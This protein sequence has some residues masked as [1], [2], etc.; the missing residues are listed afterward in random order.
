MNH[1]IAYMAFFG[2]SGAS[3]VSPYGV[4]LL[5]GRSKHLPY[6]RTLIT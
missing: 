1:I 6:N 4:D 3:I 2:T 5:S